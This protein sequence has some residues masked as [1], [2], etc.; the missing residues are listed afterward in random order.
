MIDWLQNHLILTGMTNLQADVLSRALLCLAVL[1]GVW[2]VYLILKGPVLGTLERFVTGTTRNIQWDDVLLEK[3]FFLRLIRFLPALA[4]YQAVPQVLRNTPVEIPVRTILAMLLV[5][6]GTLILESLIN[7]GKALYDS[8]EVSRKIPL[9]PFAQVLKIIL[10]FIALILLVS[11]VLDKSPLFLI[12]GLGA[13]TAV[14]LLVFRD[15]LLGFVAGIQLIG[16]RMLGEG[17]WISMPSYGADG[18]VREIT[19]T[20]VKVQNWD[21]TITTIPTYALISESFRNWRNMQL[22]G[23][24]R[25]KRSINID[26]NGIRFC[27]EE[28]LK[29]FSQIQR[30]RNFLNSRL[31]DI[32]EHNSTKT[33][34]EASI[35]DRR[36]L[37]N[38]G[39]LRYYIQHYLK[40]HPKIHKESDQWTFMVRQLPPGEKGL[41]LEIYV[42]SNDVNWVNY[43]ELQADIFDH[44]IATLPEFGL[45]AFQDPSGT[46]V[47][48]LGESA[49]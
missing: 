21:N 49:D 3:G 25:I 5:I 14:L 46:D 18:D 8:H 26:M 16:N 12:S 47:I 36:S 45:E 29:R 42:F 34:R 15:T 2:L 20:T 44:L 32:D 28:M 37:T 11:M 1:A 40:E 39:V 4:L 38:I 27:D 30:L 33:D 31:R 7:S 10:Y 6:L 48:M 22:S 43:E 41:P 9:G 19:L 35:L 13:I 24:R 17:D 23:G